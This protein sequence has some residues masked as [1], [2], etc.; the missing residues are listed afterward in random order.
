MHSQINSFGF[1][2]WLPTPFQYVR[3]F[4]LDTSHHVY[5]FLQETDRLVEVYQNQQQQP[6]K[7]SYHFQP[8]KNWM[9]GKPFNTHLLIL[10]K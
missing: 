4:E 1:T 3:V 5:T 7:I 2:K 8:P 9:N 10:F 6:Y